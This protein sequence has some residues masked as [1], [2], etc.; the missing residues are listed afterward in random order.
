MNQRTN[1]WAYKIVSNEDS[2]MAQRI[3]FSF[4]YSW[5]G[6]KQV[7][8]ENTQYLIF[9]PDDKEILWISTPENINKRVCEI[10]LSGDY[11]L[12]QARF[13]NPPKNIVQLPDWIIY[14]D[15]TVRH[16]DSE[17]EID[18]KQFRELMDAWRNFIEY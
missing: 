5:S 7:Q 6:K 15:G 12:L 1:K 4:G 14:K 10:V 8:Y 2:E 17:L 3:A 13:Q 9:N 16:I 18:P 11:A